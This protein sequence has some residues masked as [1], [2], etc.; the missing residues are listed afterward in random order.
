MMRD[1]VGNEFFLLVSDMDS[2]KSR[3]EA[4][5]QA[6]APADMLQLLGAGKSQAWFPTRDG[7]YHPDFEADWNR[8]IWPAQMLPGS[9]AWSYSVIRHEPPLEPPLQACSA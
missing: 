6:N 4:A 2:A 7:M 1:E 9:G 8:Y 5:E 3:Y